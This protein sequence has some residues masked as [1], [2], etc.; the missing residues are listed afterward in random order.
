MRTFN[1]ELLSEN[2]EPSLGFC[3]LDDCHFCVTDN[4]PLIG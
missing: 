4:H 1:V 3:T 2:A